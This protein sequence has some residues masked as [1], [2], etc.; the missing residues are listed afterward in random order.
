MYLPGAGNGYTSEQM[1]SF[2][3]STACAFSSTVQC[4][5][6]HAFFDVLEGLSDTDLSA[7]AALRVL[8]LSKFDPVVFVRV[9]NA[10]LD[11]KSAN[12]E[13]RISRAALGEEEPEGLRQELS[14]VDLPHPF[15]ARFALAASTSLALLFDLNILKAAGLA[16]CGT[17][18]EDVQSSFAHL[19]GRL[20]HML[21]HKSLE[22]S[23]PTVST[24]LSMDS[25]RWFKLAR[26]LRTTPL[27]FYFLFNEALAL[28]E[29][30]KYN[31]AGELVR[32]CLGV[33]KEV[34]GERV[35]RLEK[36]NQAHRTL[37]RGHGRRQRELR[38]KK[39]L[40]YNN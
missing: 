20:L 25:S 11:Q 32:R 12:Y 38:K 35:A 33:S 13:E 4:C 31:L 5:P 36:L 2:Y 21:R 17:S 14:E 1:V 15:A 39:K 19:V 29:T 6:P 37:S 24:A 30:E 27:P 9:A 28:C 3:R 7:G 8:Q 10:L 22:S 40:P 34:E 18:W 23:E 26:T 16:D